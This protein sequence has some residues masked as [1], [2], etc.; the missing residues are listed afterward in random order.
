V[1]LPT[2]I[3]F[4]YIF[5]LRDFSNIF[6]VMCHIAYCSIVCLPSGND[7]AFLIHCPFYWSPFSCFWAELVWSNRNRDK[8]VTLCFLYVVSISAWTQC[9][10]IGVFSPGYEALPVSVIVWTFRISNTIFFTNICDIC[11][12]IYSPCKLIWFWLICFLV[13][14]VLFILSFISDR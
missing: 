10:C 4:H 3:K 1:F 14:S 5:N 12:K 2:A 13:V 7:F 8:T 9:L 11:T 6:Q